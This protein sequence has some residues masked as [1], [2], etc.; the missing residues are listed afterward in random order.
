[1]DVSARSMD[2]GAMRV[3]DGWFTERQY[4]TRSKLQ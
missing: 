2:V 4:S 3:V 1:M